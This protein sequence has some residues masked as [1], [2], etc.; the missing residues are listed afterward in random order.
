MPGS[1]VGPRKIAELES[2]LATEDERPSLTMF[3]D[4][5]RHEKIPSKPTTFRV[6]VKNDGGVKIDDISVRVK[7][8]EPPSDK[9]NKYRDV[10]LHQKHNN[11]PP[12]DEYFS[13]IAGEEKEID[14]IAG[15]DGAATFCVCH[16]VDGLYPWVTCDLGHRNFEF[17]LEAKSEDASCEITVVVR[18][19]DNNRLIFERE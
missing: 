6:V 9:M 8:V 19:D 18:D 3:V 5:K 12:Y 1:G 16:I 4:P 2:Q 7:S 13:L 17:F 15:N 10:P 14:V 11:T